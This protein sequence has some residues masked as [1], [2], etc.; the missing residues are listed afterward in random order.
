MANDLWD[1][2]WSRNRDGPTHSDVLQDQQ[3]THEST[4]YH[5]ETTN[6]NKEEIKELIGNAELV[7]EDGESVDDDE[8]ID[9][10]Q[11]KLLEFEW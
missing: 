8:E 2:R 6:M 11:S 9:E 3:E 7:D 10:M 4:G 5:G 1:L